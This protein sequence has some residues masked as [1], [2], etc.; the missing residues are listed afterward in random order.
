MEQEPSSS[1]LSDDKETGT[2]R[3]KQ[4]DREIVYRDA[5]R[6]A[7]QVSPQSQEFHEATELHPKVQ[8]PEGMGNGGIRG[9][10]RVREEDP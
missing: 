9:A 10:K 4:M 3:R 1:I 6:Q 2:F 5:Q 7:C 8:N